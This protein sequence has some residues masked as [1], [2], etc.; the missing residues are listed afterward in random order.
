MNI[1]IVEHGKQPYAK[2]ISRGLES[3]QATV[4]GYIQTIYP[5][6]PKKNT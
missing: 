6:E 1:L 5:L 3:L 4:G 2:E